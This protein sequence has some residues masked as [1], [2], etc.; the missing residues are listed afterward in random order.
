MIFKDSENDNSLLKFSFKKLIYLFLIIIGLY[1]LLPKL[2]G[3]EQA[4]KLVVNMKWYFLILALLAEVA[5]YT[6]AAV[7]LGLIFNR[8]GYIFPFL[9]RFRISSMPAF[10]MNFLPIGLA[11]PAVFEYSYFRKNEV[12][13]GSIIV[14]WIL[15]FILNYCAF[16]IL[17]LIGL[18]LVPIYPQLSFSPKIIAPIIFIIILSFSIYA[19]YLYKHPQ[20]FWLVWVKLFN[21][22]NSVLKKFKKLPIDLDQ[23]KEIFSDIYTGIEL[24]SVKKRSSIYA[25]LSGILYWFGDMLC[26]YFVFLSFGFSVHPGILIFGYSIATILGIISA[27][28][29]GLGVV[30]GAMVLIFSSMGVPA[31]L[32]LTAVLVF[33]LFSFWIWMPIGFFSYL[34]L[35]KQ[36]SAII[37]S[38]S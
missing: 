5:S 14:M 1:L 27:V 7:L 29:G 6:G 16:L 38:S 21:F 4:L 17:F 26:L 18:I 10:T 24:F 11:G 20:K 22:V 36:N 33:R 37:K 3:L 13:S 31:A 28:P 32:A 30:E 8:I 12:E 23:Q 19:V 35:Q 2:V 34:S 15:R 25:V 9:I